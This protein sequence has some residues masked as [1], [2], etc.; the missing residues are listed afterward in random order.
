MDAR[1][2]R[3]DYI[4]HSESLRG[5]AAIQNKVIYILGVDC[6]VNKKFDEVYY[7]ARYYFIDDTDRNIFTTDTSLITKLNQ[8]TAN[9]LYAGIHETIQRNTK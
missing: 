8:D 2:K 5:Y 3:H 7:Y 4:K 1:Q 9:I 6:Q